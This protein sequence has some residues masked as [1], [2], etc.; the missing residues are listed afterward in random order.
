MSIE[1]LMN[2]EVTSVSRHEQ[3]LSQTAAAV[4]VITEE[5]ILHS[6]AKNV[7]ELLRMVPGA[8]VAQINASSW[9]ISVRGFNGRFSNKVLQCISSIAW[10]AH[11][12][13]PAPGW[14]RGSPNS[15]RNVYRSVY[16]AK[17]FCKTTIWDS[18]ISCT[19]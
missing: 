8:Q 2:V 9:A 17:I 18:R 10:S 6:S 14:T 12:L 15:G 5:D 3:T 19:P 11:R 7:P 4:F 16:S 13:L 1:D